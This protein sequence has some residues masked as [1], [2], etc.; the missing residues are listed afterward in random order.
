MFQLTIWSIPALV[1]T[2][3]AIFTL[4]RVRRYE[5]VPGVWAIRW[6]ALFVGI[7][8]LGQLLASLVTDLDAK[9][10]ASKLQ[11][12]G[13]AFTCVAWFAFA[14]TYARQRRRPS[15]RTLVAL[16][17]VPVVTV[18]LVTTN[19]LH[20]LVWHSTRLTYDRGY[21]G[22]DI[23]YGPWF[24][25]FAVYSYAILFTAT[26]ML[27]YA[28]SESSRYR[29][30]MI[31]IMAA[32]LITAA[33]N[34]IYLSPWNPLPWFDPT[35]LGFAL[36][37][38][39]LNDGV[40][41]FGLLDLTRVLRHKVVE[42]LSDGIIIVS[43]NGRI[44]DINPSAMRTLGI[45]DEE[46]LN[47]NATAL[48]PSPAIP[49]MLNQRRSSCEISLAEGSFH[50]IATPL[51]S[52]DGQPQMALVFRDIT[53]RRD[54]ELQLKRVKHQA[55]RLAQTDSLT[56]LHNRR[57]FMRRLHE[58]IE[59]V[60]R[61]GYS[62]S[63]LLVDLDFFKHINDTHGHNVGDRVLQVIANVC[64]E[65]KR[66]TDVCSRIGGEEFAI[67]LPDT[68]QNGALKLAQRLRETISD[69][70]IAAAASEAPPIRVTASI[71]AAT[72]SRHSPFLEHVL[73]Q[74]DR[75]LYQAKREGRNTV[76]AAD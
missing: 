47:R 39:L 33:L 62:L 24:R 31:A 70:L 57:Y 21:V 12:P 75:A 65:V 37:A 7:W 14:L 26:V 18:V 5:D 48:I 13:I 51:A 63:V 17:L 42:E 40:L 3:L 9:L 59:R 73:T 72:V 41:R 1:A 36:A 68:D 25:V 55:E 29:K 45:S 67:L 69:Q 43:R 15:N 61:H 64:E 2:A 56:G 34:L 46:S 44:I 50:V 30:P 32:P 20:H 74:A 28:L 49:D 8:S 60:R 27:G 11:Y 76:C 23:E 66:I 71:G 4:Y 19:E 16:G 38:L 52:E 10:I 6:L 22:L 54:Q 35:P 53:D 58:E